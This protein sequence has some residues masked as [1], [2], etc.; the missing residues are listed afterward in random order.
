LGVA[1]YVIAC[2]EYP[3]GCDGEGPG[4]DPRAVVLGRIAT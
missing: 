4:T 3:F 2:R 1:L